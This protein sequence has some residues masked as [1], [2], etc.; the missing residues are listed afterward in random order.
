[1]SRTAR[2]LQI[3]TVTFNLPLVGRQRALAFSR[4]ACPQT[5]GFFVGT[6][7][8]E[9]PGGLHMCVGDLVPPR[10]REARAH[11]VRR[12]AGLWCFV[13]YP[14]MDD[15]L[16]K[17]FDIFC[18]MGTWSCAAAQAGL[19]V[20]AGADLDCSHSLLYDINFEADFLRLGVA[21]IPA[22]RDL[23]AVGANLWLASPPLPTLVQAGP[24]AQVG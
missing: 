11:D 17:V 4:D 3:S 19:E 15:A 24:T 22:W 18:G 5:L 23:A 12:D 2:P 16:D 8:V 14:E 10:D 9:T 6:R 20:C 21:S 1:M 7:L 13:R